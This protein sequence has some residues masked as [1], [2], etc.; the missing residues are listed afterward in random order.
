MV[1]RISGNAKKIKIHLNF[2]KGFTVTHYGNI[3][4]IFQSSAL[5]L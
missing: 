2:P 4:C 1:D 5:F 3:Q